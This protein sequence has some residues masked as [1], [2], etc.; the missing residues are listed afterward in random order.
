MQTI[1]EQITESL[2]PPLYFA[3][4]LISRRAAAALPV[5]NTAAA[6]FL[7]LSLISGA[8]YFL[9]APRLTHSDCG[10]EN[11]IVLGIMGVLAGT[12]LPL[13]ALGITGAVSDYIRRKKPESGVCLV[14]SFMVF[15]LG[16][17]VMIY[18]ESILR[19]VNVC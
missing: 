2:I 5:A 18:D 8:V 15:S 16:G 6:A 14:L 12:A 7:L 4:L 9:L 3:A 13:A 10:L 19:L 1:N 11:G 17:T